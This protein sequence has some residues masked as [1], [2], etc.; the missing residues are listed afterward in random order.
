MTIWKPT[1]SQDIARYQALANAIEQDVSEG[2][3]KAGE[4]LPPH[5][6]L[7]DALGVTVGTVSRGYAEAERRGLT[8]GEVGRGTF[9]RNQSSS[10]DPWS[11]D[12][13]EPSV[14]DFSLSLPVILQEERDAFAQT[15][16]DVSEDPRLADLLIYQ[17]DSALPH[18]REAAA[19]WLGKQG[20]QCD[21]KNLLIS[22]GSQHSLNIVLP[23]L[24][25]PGQVLLTSE[26]TYPSIKSQSRAFGIRLRGVEMDEGGMCPDAL[27]RACQ[28]DPKPTALY[29]VPTLQNP[30]SIVFSRKR[31][32]AL[33]E[34]AQA[35]NL[36]IIEDDVHSML[37]PDAPQSMFSLAPTRTVYLSS[38]AKILT[39]GLRTGFIVSPSELVM[40]LRAAIHS[41]VWMAA[42]LMVEIT[43]RWLTD[44][45]AD[46]LVLAK[47]EENKIRQKMAHDILGKFH[48]KSH[49]NGI[50][51]WM[52]LP[53]PW[54]SE[55]LIA[56]ARERGVKLVGASAFAVNR[57]NV[58]QA[59]RLSIGLPSR[60]AVE[61][62]L[63][64]IE[65]LLT[66]HAGPSY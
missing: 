57:R 19:T 37:L 7:A 35:N 16:R 14:V 41:S 42:P 21:A 66:N 6:E 47:C 56:L 65:D 5:R 33:V 17:N 3:L 28:M 27:Q 10:L 64:T 34:V 50:M 48:P 2:R 52:E 25:Q 46:R 55:H 1:L 61:R 8:Y 29:I 20:V 58:P 49:P 22:T 39:P 36:W 4:R 53:E 54:Y 40:R 51:L 63:R 24:I 18:H 43:T 44:G 60:A 13:V 62:G 26:L 59:V 9:I 15:L 45:T 32:E 11:E 23:T 30:T 31:R 12:L 38:V